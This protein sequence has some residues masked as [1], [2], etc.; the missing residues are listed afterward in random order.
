MHQTV[1]I[2]GG[3]FDGPLVVVED[4]IQLRMAGGGWGIGVARHC[5]LSDNKHSE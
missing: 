4:G 3:L 5:S 2:R 1:A